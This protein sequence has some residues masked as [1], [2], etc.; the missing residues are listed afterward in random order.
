MPFI[1]PKSIRA[2]WAL[3]VA[4][5]ALAVPASPAIAASVAECEGQLFSHPFLSLNDHNGYT[6]VPGSNFDRASEGWMLSNGASIVA[7][8]RPDGTTGNVMNLPSRAVAVSP[9]VCVTLAYPKARVAV[10]NVVGAEGVAVNVAYA[11]TNTEKS[12]KNV[13]QV[14]G[15]QTR[16]TESDPFNVQP[17]TAGSQEGTRQVRFVFEGK[18]TTSLFQIYELWI[19][20]YGR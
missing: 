1:R 6:L 2:M 3:A 12:P 16:W 5:A 15:Q 10:R 11:G 4:A 18:G 20:P 19:D 14:H 9:P 8:T 17:Q 13:G 7:T